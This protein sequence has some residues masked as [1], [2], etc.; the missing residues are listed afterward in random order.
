MEKCFECNNPAQA[1]HHVVPKVLGG[2]KTV[3]LCDDC[4][5]KVHDTDMLKLASLIRKQRKDAGPPKA[6]RGYW[7]GWRPYG[8]DVVDNILVDNEEEQ[9]IIKDML[10]WK[11]KG[12]T[13]QSIKDTL[14]KNAILT[15]QNR[16][17]WHYMSVRRIIERCSFVNKN[18]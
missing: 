14:N 2:T 12:M 16:A 13:I 10:E 4:Q 15:V 9:K 3:L 11:N 1:Q 18:K 8:F 5:S 17:P 7:G 6:G